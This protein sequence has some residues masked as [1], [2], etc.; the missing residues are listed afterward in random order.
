MVERL[1]FIMKA[2]NLSMT[3]FADA[4][5]VQ[6]SSMSHVMNGRNKASLD[7][8]TRVLKKYPDINSDWLLFGEGTMQKESKQISIE[9]DILLQEKKKEWEHEKLMMQNQID[10]LYNQIKN[11]KIQKKEITQIKDIPIVKDEQPAVYKTTKKEVK[12]IVTF[13][14]DDTFKAFYPG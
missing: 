8:I 1:T 12:S 4:I 11:L 9:Q 14:A 3:Q 5:D 2:K 7:F 6:R 10:E 13:Y